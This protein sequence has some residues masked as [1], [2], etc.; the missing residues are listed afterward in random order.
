MVAARQ[1]DTNAEPIRQT[2]QRV[3]AMNGTIGAMS[4]LGKSFLV[5]AGRTGRGETGSH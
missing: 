5:C 4:S 1:V 3:T 2:S